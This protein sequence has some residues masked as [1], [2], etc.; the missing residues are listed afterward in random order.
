MINSDV[1][2]FVDRLRK[3]YPEHDT[4]VG[5]IHPYWARKPL[6]IIQ[7]L[8][9]SF[10]T[11]KDLIVDPFV[12]SG[13]T[14]FASLLQGRKVVASDLNPLS[15]FITKSL[16]ELCLSSEKKKEALDQFVVDL[17]SE[18]LRWF[19]YEDDWYVERERF[20]VIGDFENGNYSLN[21]EEVV[22][23]VLK[24]G[25]FSGRRVEKITTSWMSNEIPE[26]LLK[27]PIDFSLL[28]LLPNSRI[29]IPNGVNLSH[30]Y[31]KKNRASINVALRLIKSNK[32][33]IENT[34]VLKLLLSSCL[35]L[36]RLSDRKASSQWPYWRPKNHLTSRNP[37]FVFQKRLKAFKEAIVWFNKNISVE[38]KDNLS[39]YLELIN[40]PIQTL[41]PDYVKPCSVDLVVTDPPYSDQ[42]PY[43]EYSSLWIQILNLP[44]LE[45][46]YNYEIV[47][48]DAPDRI[49]DS[50]DYPY[51]LREAL[52]VC[53]EMIKFDGSIIWF[54][55]DHVLSHWALISEEA[56]VNN[57]F[58]VDVIPLPK[59][60][61][62]IKTVTTPGKTLDG[63]LILIFRKERVTQEV[64][65]D[66]TQ[67]IGIIKQALQERNNITTYFDKYALVVEISLK[68]NMM[69][70][71]A[72]SFSDIDD[73]LRIF[74]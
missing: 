37:V 71:L 20:K 24:S 72:K 13:T 12:G 57:L 65:Y 26:Y 19:H 44:I 21:N 9:N 52:K 42:V 73:F 49:K 67:A 40:T 66:I 11:E 29:A 27:F 64:V 34:D 31:D 59:Q 18:I 68:Y 51:R 14:V 50:E 41:L 17:S 16:V 5:L 4:P 48:T 45:N 58:I 43:L 22:L 62:S 39:N 63:D 28:S 25:R 60:R 38:V 54:Y 8:I 6:N 56:R 32:Y 23:K 55:Q 61:R 36:L 35:P 74:E 3:L 30:Y 2:G 7:E 70:L 69:P 15:I 47:K 53:S 10:S 1:I 33:G 46:A